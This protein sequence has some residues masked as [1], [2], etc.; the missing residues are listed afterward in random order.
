MVQQRKFYA[1]N[2]FKIVVKIGSTRFLHPFGIID[3]QLGAAETIANSFLQRLSFTFSRGLRAWRTLGS[4]QATACKTS[5]KG[6]MSD[7]SF[8]QPPVVSFCDKR[9]LLLRG[10]LHN[11]RLARMFRRPEQG[12]R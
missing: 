5:R 10:G 2:F 3:S 1:T 6:E 7:F 11:N 8:L 4:L 9:G 12:H